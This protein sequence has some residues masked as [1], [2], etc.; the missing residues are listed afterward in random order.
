MKL[1][2][3]VEE[4]SWN[5]FDLNFMG[6]KALELALLSIHINSLNYEYSILACDNNRITDLNYKF[7]EKKF[8]TDILSWPEFDLKNAKPGLYP[9][10]PPISE[11]AEA[12]IDLGNIAIAYEACFNEL[13]NTNINHYDHLMHL[14]LHGCL[15]LLGFDHQDSS[16]ASLMESIEISSLSSLGISNPY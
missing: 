16:D 7:R 12:L 5:E 8:P 2:I 3:L 4:K 14:L 11:N 6:S 1:N 10:S 15:H 9:K 13:E